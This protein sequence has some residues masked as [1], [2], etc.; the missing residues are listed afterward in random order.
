VH[1]V[2]VEVVGAELLERVLD[3]ELDVLRVVVDLKQLGGDEELGSVDA[4]GSDTL[5]DLSLVL[6]SP[7][8]A[9]RQLCREQGE[10][11]HQLDVPVSSLRR[12]H[13][14]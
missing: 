13:L 7:G 10:G 2:Q 3:G 8:A 14:F 1:Q 9:A 12:Q 5:S 6:V 4:R 11:V